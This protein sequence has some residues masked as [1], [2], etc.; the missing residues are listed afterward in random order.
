MPITSLTGSLTSLLKQADAACYAAKD[1]GRNRVHVY[2]EDDEEL[3]KKQGEM[4]WV[5]R[6]HQCLEEDQFSLGS[7]IFGTY[8]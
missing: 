1:L 6:I 7:I 5:E 2:S 4:R 8:E 3:L